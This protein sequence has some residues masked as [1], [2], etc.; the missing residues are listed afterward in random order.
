M[1]RV[2]RSP[3]IAYRTI[4]GEAAI[5]TVDDRKLHMLNEVGTAIFEAVAAPK[6]V[7][8]VA[9]KV[10]AS[11]IVTEEVALTDVRSFCDDLVRRKILELV[12]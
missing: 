4:D 2:R 10:A 3:R 6:T 5:V 1:S 11:F 9:A 12:E 7:D 8:E